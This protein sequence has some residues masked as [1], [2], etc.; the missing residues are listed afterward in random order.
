MPLAGAL[1]FTIGRVCLAVILALTAAVAC[2]ADGAGDLLKH[3]D[4]VKTSNHAEFLEVLQRL[5]A[6]RDHLSPAQQMYLRYLDAYKLAFSGDYDRAVPQLTAITRESNDVVLRFRAGITLTNILA[7]SAHFEEAYAHLNELLELQP[8]IDDKTTR[9]LGFGIAALLYNQAGQYDLAML[10]AQ[11]WL[12]E[13]GDGEGGCKANYLKVEALYRTGKLA[14][15]SIDVRN[16]LAACARIADPVYANLIRTFVANLAIDQQRAGSAIKL[17][18]DNYAEIQGTRYNRLTSEVDSI[19]ARAWFKSGDLDQATRY[20]LSAVDKSVR[21]EITK[22]LVDAYQVLY[23]IARNRSDFQTALTYHEK[24]AAAD[25]GYL[26]E[27]STRALAFQM[28]NQQVLD[29]KRLVDELSEKNQLLRLSQQVS[30]K[31]EEAERLYILLLLLVIGFIVLWTYRLKRSQLRFQKLAR[32]DGL[33][34]IVNR[35]HFMDEAKAML[36]A[37]A[38]SQREVCLIL[39]DLDNFKLVNDTHGHVAGDGVLKQT[40]EMFQLHMRVADLFGRLGGEE[41]GIMLPNCTLETAFTRAEELRAAIGSF[42]QA[43]VTITVSASFGVTSTVQS[44]YDLRQLLI[45]ADSA[46][47]RAKRNGRDRVESYVPAVDAPSSTPPPYAEWDI[48]KT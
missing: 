12:D 46:L 7:L 21:D 40:V 41:F 29:K 6:D 34:G 39:V 13:D 48:S 18:Q 15:D 20:A 8:K 47:Y 4:D 42:A 19:L 16:G 44:G 28:V 32:R 1:R 14:A 27:T 45:H 23:E 3:A 25:K 11:R 2:A 35:Q 24:Y 5:D 31:S 9:M 22:P 33:T 30:E 37:C 17:F 10:N 43:G 36:Q 38:R 26:G